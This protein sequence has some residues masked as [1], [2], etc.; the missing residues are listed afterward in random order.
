MNHFE[1]F[2]VSTLHYIPL[3][4]H[5]T[6]R[7]WISILDSCRTV[8]V[9]DPTVSMLDWRLYSRIEETHLLDFRLRLY[10][11]RMKRRIAAMVAL[12]CAAGSQERSEKTTEETEK[13]KNDCQA[14]VYQQTLSVKICPNA[15]IRF[16][17]WYSAWSLYCVHWRRYAPFIYKKNLYKLYF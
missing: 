15:A 10:S 9:S 1:I 8:I 16:T 13:G 17:L 2:Y 3:K 4:I 6:F 14:V 11:L 5:S 12:C 7:S